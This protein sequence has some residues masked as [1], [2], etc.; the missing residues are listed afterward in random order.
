MLLLFAMILSSAISRPYTPD[1]NGTLRLIW[2]TDTHNTTA[3]LEPRNSGVDAALADATTYGADAVI[4]TGDI[5]N[6]TPANVAAAFTR[7]RGTAI[8]CPLITVIGNHDEYEATPGTTNATQLEGASY[9][10]RPAPFVLSTTLAA[11][12]GNLVARVLALD[13]NVYDEN[14]SDPTRVND[15][16]D[17]GERV[18]YSTEEPAGGSWRRFNQDQLDWFAAELAADTTSQVLLLLSHYPPSGAG[19]TNYKAIADLV[20][21]DGR[22]AILLCG[23]QHGDARELTL[24]STDTLRRI[25]CF[26]CPAMQESGSW[27]RV[28]LRMTAGV[29]AL[30]LLEIHNFTNPDAWVINPPFTLA[31]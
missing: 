26:K 4:H 31:G 13:C 20:Q 15:A 2:L 10:D 12:D 29:I 22:P 19:P 9:F 1:A 30:D 21:A 3:S 8:P 25:R 28:Q 16:H 17:P 6:D 7:L 23:H 27:T 18:G 5:G 14:A 11:S 24:T